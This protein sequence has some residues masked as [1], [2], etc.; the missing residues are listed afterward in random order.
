MKTFAFAQFLHLESVGAFL[1]KFN[2]DYT[3]HIIKRNCYYTPHFL[4]IKM[5]LIKLLEIDQ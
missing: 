3:K 2:P 4:F 5:A 1:L